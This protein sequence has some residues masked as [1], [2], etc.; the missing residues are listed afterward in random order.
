MLLSKP[1]FSASALCLF[2]VY[3]KPPDATWKDHRYRQFPKA[4]RAIPGCHVQVPNIDVC[5]KCSLIN[6]DK[7]VAILRIALTGRKALQYVMQQDIMSNAAN[8]M[9]MQCNKLHMHAGHMQC[10]THITCLYVHIGKRVYV[11]NHQLGLSSI[12]QKGRW[13]G[14]DIST[15]GI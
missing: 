5:R 13:H 14:T 2:V 15:R 8:N 6:A 9:C 11:H 12:W 10:N 3:Q 7:N 4:L 1:W